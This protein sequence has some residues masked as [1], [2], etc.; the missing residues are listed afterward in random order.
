MVSIDYCIL[1]MEIM[2]IY[3]KCSSD[4]DSQIW[5]WQRLLN[6]S[7]LYTKNITKKQVDSNYLFLIEIMVRSINNKCT[8]TLSLLSPNSHSNR[9]IYLQDSI[10]TFNNYR[11]IYIHST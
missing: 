7:Q 6:F 2:E 4:N 3:D 8:Y 1:T 9:Y 10:S 5:E 11:S